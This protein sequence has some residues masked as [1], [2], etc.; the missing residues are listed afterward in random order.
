MRKHFFVDQ[1]VADR[2]KLDAVVTVADAV[3]L[4]DQ[5]VE[6][7]EAEEQIAFTD[8]ILLNKTDLVETSRL[9]SIEKRI[10][11]INPYAKIIKTAHCTAPLTEV[12]GLDAFSLERILE[13]E[14]THVNSNI[15]CV[16]NN[17]MSSRVVNAKICKSSTFK[18]NEVY[19]KN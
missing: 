16:G 19:R 3:H 11:K 6:H 2:T 4:Q 12:L 5:L 7:H 15:L 13:V 14:L 17:R 8:V 18:P 10:R 1:D 9:E